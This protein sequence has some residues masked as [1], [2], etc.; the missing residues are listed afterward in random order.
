M[1]KKRLKGLWHFI[2][3]DN[4]IWSWA[5]NVILA[6]V[7]I[8]FVVYPVLGLVLGTTHPIV[9]VVSGSME[10]EGKP[11]EAWWEANKAYYESIGI[12]KKDFESF[13]MKNGFNRG[14]IIILNR[15]EKDKLKQGDII[16]FRSKRPDPII[17][18]ITGFNTAQ[19]SFM[20]KGDHNPSPISDDTLNE[21]N[22]GSSSII[23]KAALKIPFL[24]YIKIWFVDLLN[25][26]IKLVGASG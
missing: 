10:H 2:W 19:G 4:S 14:D 9:A 17:H 5:V 16:V 18:R 3:D 20:T 1:I 8:K 15:A 6:F 12:K 7:L 26:I 13:T 11:F 24:G 23:G 22:V 21:N 25:M